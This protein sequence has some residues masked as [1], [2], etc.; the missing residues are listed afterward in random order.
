MVALLSEPAVLDY[1]Y[2]V[3]FSDRGEAMCTVDYCLAPHDILQLTH[4][5]L[6]SVSVQVTGCLIEQEYFSFGFQE[7]PCDQNTLTLSA[8]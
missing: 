6:L 8:R 4:D 1:V 3:D 7:A 5:C 2:P